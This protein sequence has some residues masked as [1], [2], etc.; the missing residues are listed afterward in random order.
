MA[1]N[2]RWRAEPGQFSFYDG[3]TSPVLRYYGSTSPTATP[4]DFCFRDYY[5]SSSG[6]WII[7][8]SLTP[9]VLIDGSVLAAGTLSYNRE[10]WFYSLQPAAAFFYSAARGK[11]IYF[12]GETEPKEPQAAI[13]LDDTTWVGD[14]WWEDSNGYGAFQYMPWTL[15]P[16][17]AALNDP[18][19][20]DLTAAIN[21]PRWIRDASNSR[22]TTAPCGTYTAESGSG[23]SPSTRTIGLPVWTGTFSV[24][25]T[26]RAIYFI[27]SFGMSGGRYSYLTEGMT[28]ARYAKGNLAW[29]S[30]RS[31]YVY[32]SVGEGEW[33]ETATAPTIADGATLESRRLDEGGNVVAGDSADVAL[34]FD[35][36][37]FGSEKET[38]YIA[39]FVTWR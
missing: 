25:G 30:S 18:G 8:P 27:R 32:G 16:A 34:A 10:P 38:V 17:G 33:F 20:D 26:N 23:L 31:A 19:N 3:H 15:S 11:W 13:G 29:D 1:A 37:A 12:P 6:P 22:N 39:E 4:S 14:A 28:N 24:N 7:A 35:R 21:W 2:V 9:G 36:Y 5:S